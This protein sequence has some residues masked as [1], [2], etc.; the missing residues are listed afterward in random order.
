MLTLE[1]YLFSWEPSWTINSHIR[2]P[3]NS[4][5]TI[6]VKV[7]DYIWQQRAQ[8][9]MCNRLS[10]VWFTL[11]NSPDYLVVHYNYFKRG[12][13]QYAC[14]CFDI[15]CL[16]SDGCPFLSC[17][18]HHIKHIGVHSTYILVL[19]FSQILKFIFTCKWY[20]CWNWCGAIFT[21]WLQKINCSKLF[22]IKRLEL[23]ML[24]DSSTLL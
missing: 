4:P 6:I 21:R 14:F 24:D 8:E 15:N 9:K 20:S 12:A 7:F 5:C 17:F 19:I 1:Y 3:I 22:T 18:S 11:I 16:Q 2:L 13:S 23:L 10:A